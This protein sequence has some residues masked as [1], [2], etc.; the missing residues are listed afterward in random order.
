MR[1]VTIVPWPLTFLF[2]GQNWQ[3][4]YFCLYRGK[5]IFI[6]CIVVWNIRNIENCGVFL[7]KTSIKSSWNIAC[8][9]TVWSKHLFCALVN[10]ILLFK[11]GAASNILSAV[12][13]MLWLP[14]R[15]SLMW[16]FLRASLPLDHL[17]PPCDHFPHLYG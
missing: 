15:V 3:L 12:V 1:K 16:S 7:A 17:C 13:S 11:F 2:F 10:I 6:S 8:L 14:L 9:L 5:L 4:I